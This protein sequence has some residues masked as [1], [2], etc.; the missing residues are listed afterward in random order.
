MSQK[1]GGSDGGVEGMLVACSLG[2]V[3][4]AVEAQHG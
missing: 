3:A 2:A 1:G 4:K